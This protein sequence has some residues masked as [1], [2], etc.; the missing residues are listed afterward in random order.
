MSTQTMPPPLPAWVE[1]IQPRTEAEAVAVRRQVE[2]ITPQRF[3]RWSG[4]TIEERFIAKV[5]F[6][7]D[8]WVWTDSRMRSGYGRMGVAGKM[9]L[10]HRLAWEIANGPIP[11]GMYVCHRCDNPSCVRPDHLFL[12]TPADNVKD[13]VAK[14]RAATGEKHGSRT[15]PASRARGDRNGSRRHPERLPNGLEH[16]AAKLSADGVREIRKIRAE[17][18]I[19]FAEI[20]KRFGIHAFNARR[21]ALGLSYKD[22]T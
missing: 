1:A 4:T 8:C 12:G 21:A 5:D 16:H 13:M 22:V 6:S 7:S 19:S 17:E 10:A 2:Q 20:G 3:H 9:V 11:P 15:Q 18:G 14:G